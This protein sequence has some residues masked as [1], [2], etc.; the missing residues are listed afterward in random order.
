MAFPLDSARVRVF[1]QTTRTG[2]N[3]S[4]RLLHPSW[5]LLSKT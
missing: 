2:V 5:L 3:L 4:V 1:A